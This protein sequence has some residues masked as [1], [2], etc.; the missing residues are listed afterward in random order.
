MLNVTIAEMLRRD[1]TPEEEA[2]LRREIRK[3]NALGPE[4]PL[5]REEWEAALKGWLA[6]DDALRA[7][8]RDQD[9]DKD[10]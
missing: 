2:E 4:E 10:T 8:K 5:S 1:P 9:T 7:R 3:R 6:E